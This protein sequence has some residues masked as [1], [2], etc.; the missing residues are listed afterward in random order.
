MIERHVRFQVPA[1]SQA[2]FIRFADRV[3]FPALREQPGF[4]H[5]SLLQE[6]GAPG[7]HVM[8]LRFAEADQAAAWRSSARHQLLSAEL[9]LL[10][11]GSEVSVFEVVLG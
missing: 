9:K 5:G 6:S 2:E 4:I 11:E 10:H 7:R 1:V 3:Y 8:V